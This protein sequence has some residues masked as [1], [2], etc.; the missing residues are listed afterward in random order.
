MLFSS[1]WCG[2]RCV[3]RNMFTSARKMLFRDSH[4]LGKC[5]R[6]RASKDLKTNVRL[7]AI[8]DDSCSLIFEKKSF[9]WHIG[10]NGKL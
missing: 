6:N 1:G 8:H 2:T 9:P 5:I 7:C 10:T 4:K 3:P